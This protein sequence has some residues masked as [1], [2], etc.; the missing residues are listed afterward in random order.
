MAIPDVNLVKYT[1]QLPL[2]VGFDGAVLNADTTPGYAPNS[3][4]ST[5]SNKLSTLNGTYATGLIPCTP[6]STI[7]MQNISTEQANNYDSVCIFDANDTNG[8]GFQYTTKYTFTAMLDDANF[9]TVV[10]ENGTLIEFTLPG[11]QYNQTHFAICSQEISA[12]SIITV[13]EP[14]E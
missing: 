7:R 3:R 13:D 10:D 6:T 9:K 11:W 2:A 1:N 5:S 14:I 12:D 4:Y 8:D